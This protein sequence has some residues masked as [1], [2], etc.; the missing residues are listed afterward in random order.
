M[1]SS[2]LEKLYNTKTLTLSGDILTGNY[3]FVETSLLYLGFSGE[4]AISGS[5]ITFTCDGSTTT[6]MSENYNS[7][8]ICANF[9]GVLSDVSTIKLTAGSDTKFIVDGEEKTELSFSA[10]EV[11]DDITSASFTYESYDGNTVKLVCSEYIDNPYNLSLSTIQKYFAVTVE[12]ETATITDFSIIG[13]E[14]TLTV[15]KELAGAVNIKYTNNGTGKMY[16][17]IDLYII[18]NFSID[19][20]IVVEPE[21]EEEEEPKT[22][23][24]DKKE[25]KKEED[26]DKKEEGNITTESSVIKTEDKEELMDA[27]ILP[28][29]EEEEMEEIEEEKAETTTTEEGKI[30]Y[31]KK[32]LLNS[33][34]YKN[35]KDI[36]N[37]I[38]SNDEALTISEIDARIEEFNNKVV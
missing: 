12:G 31:S 35:Q 17:P 23:E 15:D 18:D 10:Y 33:E 2:T 32:S 19:L 13:R 21:E 3:T 20:D 14:V 29:E 22:D 5:N 6:S 30:R 34:R 27:V 36:I 4:F 28:E 8:L 7:K 11:V 1:S 37:A 25:D 16:T 38:V 9:D 26:E 24:E